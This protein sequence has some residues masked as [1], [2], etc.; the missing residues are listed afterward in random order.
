M[1]GGCR[2]NLFDVVTFELKLITIR[3]Q[4]IIEE[5]DVDDMGDPKLINMHS[6]RT[7]M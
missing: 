3:L 6:H 5:E 2:M 7:T 4:W 1:G